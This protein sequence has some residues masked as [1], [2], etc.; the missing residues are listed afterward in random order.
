MLGVVEVVFAWVLEKDAHNLREEGVIK[1][2]TIIYT[3][4]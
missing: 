1:D 4:D 2:G 3:I